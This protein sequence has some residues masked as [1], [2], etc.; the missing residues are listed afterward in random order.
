MLQAPEIM[1]PAENPLP[2]VARFGL[3]ALLMAAPL[4][5]GAVQPW[6]W[7]TMTVV[8]SC[9][10]LLWA[11][12]CVRAGRLTLLWSPLY[13]PGV[14]LLV[15]AAVQL[16]FGLTR[17][18]IGTREAVIKLA[19]CLIIFF[20]AQH[21]FEEASPPV[22]RTAGIAIGVYLLA[23]AV[24][25]ILQAFAWPGLLYGVVKPR[26]DGYLFGPYVNHN[27]Y[28]GL[29]EALLPLTTGSLLTLPEGH[30]WK[31]IGMFALL[32]G[33]SSV[34]LCGSRS[35]T[36]AALLELAMFLLIMAGR[37]APA[38]GV[39]GCRGRAPGA[40]AVGVLGWRGTPAL[41][42]LGVVMLAAALF[43]FLDAGGVRNRWTEAADSPEAAAG[44]RY[45]MTADALR[46][47]RDEPVAGF[48]MGAFSAAYPRY[49][50]W[51]TDLAVDHA[52]NDYAEFLAE[53]GAVGGAILIAGIALLLGCGFG[54]LSRRLAGPAGWMRTAGAI[55]CCG[56]LLHS[57][58]DFNLH[59]PANA[60]W[61]SLAAAFAT[62]D[63]RR[64]LHP[65]KP[66]T[67]LLGTPADERC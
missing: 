26:W 49:Q 31:P 51:A 20:L 12:G 57:F 17:D 30:K 52:H 33:L 4:A 60:A 62:G 25:A 50:S 37:P 24:F 8:A 1:N 54:G 11:L 55:G 3:L 23:I 27:H 67:G 22:W 38:V 15:L 16:R 64:S 34:L 46:I 61:F 63:R 28:A 10:L 19:T 39:L 42:G 7:G 43:A 9:L 40:P 53:T 48:G 36:L 65:S 14:A 5:F 13:V 6:A 45:S 18:E 47:W 59:I 35:G 2:A 29:M 21:L 58:T 44:A 32:V 41:F 56:L 66:N